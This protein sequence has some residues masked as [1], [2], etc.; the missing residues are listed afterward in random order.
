MLDE[1]VF[2][3]EELEFVIYLDWMVFVLLCG[4]FKEIDKIILFFYIL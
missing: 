3:S 4:V 2:V 1:L